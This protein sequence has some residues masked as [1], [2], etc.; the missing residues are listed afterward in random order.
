MVPMDEL[1]DARAAT[2][3]WRR[4]TLWAA[5]AVAILAVVYGLLR[6]AGEPTKAGTAAPEFSLARLTGSGSVS[7]ADLKGGPVVINFWA[8]WCDPCR[9]EAPLLEAAWREHR[10]EGLTVLGVDLKDAPDNA[11]AFIDEHGLTYPTV[12]DPDME[13]ARALGIGSTDGLPQTFFVDSG[14]RLQPVEGDAAGEG[15]VVVLGALSED[16]LDDQ[17]ARLLDSAG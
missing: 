3:K 8:S 15:G 5:A 6:P 2:R 16:L 12:T 11:R 10:D 17:I 14:W 9:E 13:L 4:A 7:S 1:E